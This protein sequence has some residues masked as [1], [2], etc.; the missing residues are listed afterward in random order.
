MITLK[1][2]RTI[3]ASPEEVFAVLSDPDRLSSLLPRIQRI[4]ILERHTDHARLATHM[5][6]GNGL[7]T[8]R[9]EG[10]LRWVAPREITFT[11]RKPLPV[12]NN[13]TLQA[14]PGGTEI[15]VTMSLDLTP[16]LG[17]FAKFVP[18]VAVSDMLSQDI[19]ATLTQ[20]ARY[21]TATPNERAV[22][23]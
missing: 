17:P 19:E 1:R 5:A 20:I 3:P 7:G 21:V 8:V 15:V 13:W 11:V 16:M 14:V 18:T 12:E 9:C 6:I 22:A 10:D 4:E 23:A 2:S